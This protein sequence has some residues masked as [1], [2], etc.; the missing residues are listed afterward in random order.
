M[1][2]QTQR[3]CIRAFCAE[4]IEP[5]MT[6][7]ND[8]DWM[9]YQAFKGLTRDVYERELL[10]T[11]SLAEGVQLAVVDAATGQLVGDVFLQQEGDAF[12]LGYTI[13]PACARQGYAF[14]A[15]T[16]VIGWCKTQGGRVM[17]AGILPQNKASAGLLEK[18]GFQH[19]GE[20]DG[21]QI[22][23]LPL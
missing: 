1:L 3:C 15:A 6:Y 21:E 11:F 7:R 20:R 22:Y 5:F 4:D 12:W 8:M 16:A 19:A 10:G 17:K 13:R 2:I 18:L 14:E 23:T 9:R